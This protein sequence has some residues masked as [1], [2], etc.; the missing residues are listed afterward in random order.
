MSVEGCRGLGPVVG[1]AAID[2][3][4][5]AARHNGIAIAA[6]RNS[7]HLGMLAWYAE[8]IAALGLIGIVL[9]TS[10]ALVHPFGG[11]R[12]MLGTNPIAIGVPMPAAEPF[13]LDLATSTVSMG[14]I[15]DHAL[16]RRAIPEDWALDADGEPTTDP[17]EAMR[18]S[19]AP[20]GGAKGYGLGL[21]FELLVASLAGSAFAPDVRGTLDAEH[22]CNKGDVFI[23]V[24]PLS[25]SGH[26]VADYLAA[27]RSS[28]STSPATPVGIPGDGSRARRRAALT[29]G[30]EIADAVWDQLTSLAGAPA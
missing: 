6:V 17:K 15:H 20:F 1:A 23:L 18:G 29:R 2:A 8:R 4:A 30:I 25:G 24:E 14:K 12:A 7:N 27:L 16:K 21:A 3:L 5:P 22:P 28:P 9:S 13:V 11:R 26:A 10:E 19:L